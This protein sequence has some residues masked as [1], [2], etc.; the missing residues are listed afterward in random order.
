MPE[1]L[2]KCA[3]VFTGDCDPERCFGIG[4]WAVTCNNCGSSFNLNTEGRYEHNGSTTEFACPG[5]PLPS[6]W[7]R[8]RLDPSLAQELRLTEGI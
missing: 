5:C 2:K 7:V 6:E 8:L 1:L 4:V 3:H